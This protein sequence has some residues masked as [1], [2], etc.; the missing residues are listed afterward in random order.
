IFLMA[1]VS[2]RG[3][4]FGQAIA[5]ANDKLRDHG[6]ILSAAMYGDVALIAS[7]LTYVNEEHR[8][9]WGGGLFNDIRSRI[10]RS[11][12]RSDDL[13]FVSWERFF[14]AEALA[15]YPFTRFSFLQGSIAAGGSE[16]FLLDDTR[17]ALA[18]PGSEDP[19]SHNLYAPWLANN[20]DLRFQTEGSLSLG[21]DTIGMH[22]ATGPI[23]GSSALLSLSVG[24]QPWHHMTYEQV[25]LDAEHYF[26]ITG[27]VNFFVRGGAG[28]TSGDSHAPSYFLSSFHTLRG[29]PF[30]DTDYLLGREFVYTTFELQF[31]ILEFLSFPLID[32]EGVL[33][34]DVGSVADSVESLW[35]RRLLDLVFGTNLGFGPIVIAIH[36]A[37]PVDIGPV[38]TPNGGSLTF[39]LSLNWRYQ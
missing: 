28:T 9:I 32:L 15:R 17:K 16:Y 26:P 14:G 23:R 33:G 31:P 39:N 5:G 3:S 18:R 8:L 6:L 19:S 7:S 20:A 27:A 1:G 4:I 25:R 35:R 24:T 29:V 37:Q 10:D 12:Q 13:W 21:Y 38:P 2:N 22:R 34:A 11:F 30:G 36:F